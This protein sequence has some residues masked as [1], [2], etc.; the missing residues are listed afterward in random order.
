[1]NRSQPAETLAPPPFSIVIETE[2]LGTS[3]DTYLFLVGTNGTTILAYD[4]D[5]GGALASRIEWAAPASGTYFARVRHF[6]STESGPNTNYDLRVRTSGSSAGQYEPNDTVGQA[7]TIAESAARA[8]SGRAAATA[9]TSWPAK[10]S[11]SPTATTAIAASTP[12]S[13]SA[14]PTSIFSITA[15]GNGQRKI[16][17]CSMSGIEMSWV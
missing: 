9:A 12:G 11:L 2:N 15:Q 5:S 17:P 13:S 10:I 8:C 3:S 14:G 4:D 7:T 1:M 6:S 16:A